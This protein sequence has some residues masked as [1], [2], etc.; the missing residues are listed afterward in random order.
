MEVKIFDKVV[1]ISSRIGSL[2][3][4]NSNLLKL[5]RRKFELYCKFPVKSQ[6]KNSINK[7]TLDLK[8]AGPRLKK[9]SWASTLPWS[10]QQ[11]C[12][13]CAMMSAQVTLVIRVLCPVIKGWSGSIR[14]ISQ[15]FKRK[16]WYTGETMLINNRTVTSRYRACIENSN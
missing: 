5:A 9:T 6:K 1:R 13:S 15:K 8:I 10:C 14:S 16:H 2:F 3:G 7:Q 11:S 4:K 12:L